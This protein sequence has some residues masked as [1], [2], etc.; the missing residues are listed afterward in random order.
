MIDAAGK[1]SNLVAAAGGTGSETSM[2][3]GSTATSGYGTKGDGTVALGPGDVLKEYDLLQE[4]PHGATL[5]SEG[6]TFTAVARLGYHG[7]SSQ[8]S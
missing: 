8:D 6:S 4:Q 2:E 5:G 7:V 1:L 3:I